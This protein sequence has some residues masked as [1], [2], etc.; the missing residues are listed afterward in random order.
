ML[1]P[2]S[3]LCNEEN[4]LAKPL[5]HGDML[6]LGAPDNDESTISSGQADV[7]KPSP[8]DV[9]SVITQ[10]TT[11]TAIRGQATP[12]FRV[13][14]HPPQAKTWRKRFRSLL[15][16]FVPQSQGYYRP[17]EGDFVGPRLLPPQPPKVHREVLIGPKRSDDLDRKTLVLDLDETLVHS[18]FKPI[19][20]PGK[21][22][23]GARLESTDW[24]RHTSQFCVY[25]DQ[26]TKL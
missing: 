26:L 5:V 23:T 2:G 7:Q 25:R 16:C 9:S 21:R 12:S 20:N 4:I 11:V 19:P 24:V 8:V 6:P 22:G 3:T 17:Q 15:C 14:S 18:S 13:T 10:V 1:P